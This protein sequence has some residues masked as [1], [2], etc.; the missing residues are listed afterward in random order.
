MKQ[1][2]KQAEPFSAENGQDERCARRG[3]GRKGKNKVTNFHMG[4][5][6]PGKQNGTAT[7]ASAQNLNTRGSETK[8][9]IQGGARGQKRGGED[10]VV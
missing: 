2:K 8:T 9:L 10:D 1:S 6:S 7:K 3:G 5:K 4:E